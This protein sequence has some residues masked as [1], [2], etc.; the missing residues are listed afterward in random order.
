[1]GKSKNR[2]RNRKKRRLSQGGEDGDNTSNP[3]LSP[4]EGEETSLK[5]RSPHPPNKKV[6]GQDGPPA[7]K[8]KSPKH[9]EKSPGA[10]KIALEQNPLLEAQQ[11]LLN[12]IPK[13]RRDNFFDNNKVDPEVRAELWMKQADVGEDL[14]NRYAWATPDNR[15]MTILNHFSP[16]VEIG[17]GAN[18][19]WL[20]MAIQAGIDM[21]G[22]DIQ[23]EE[24][25]LI[26]SSSSE[27]SSIKKNKKQKGSK[28]PIKQGGPEVLSMPELKDSKRTLF[29]CYPDEDVEGEEE[30]RY[31]D[32]ADDDEADEKIESMA[33]RCLEHYSGTHVIHV[34]E[35]FSDANLSLDQAPWGRSSSPEFQ[36]RLASEYHCV[37]KIELPSWLH[38]RDTL[39]VW[40]RSE[41]CTMVFAA[42]SD[43]EDDDEDEE[44]EYRHIPPKER[45]PSSIAAPYLQHLL[46]EN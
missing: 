46:A 42:D 38:V 30:I 6:E 25:G 45:L 14:I 15:A 34:G 31:E 20:R 22:Y 36:Q 21:I 41:I 11:K 10:N 37:L 35:L 40:K 5:S 43:D 27:M 19:Y 4:G 44:L 23:P 13:K 17:C 33:F 26:S 29:L 7:S 18:A 32:E 39:S 12:S 16:L 1:M 8:Q 28:L 3:P 24:G 9:T 2:N